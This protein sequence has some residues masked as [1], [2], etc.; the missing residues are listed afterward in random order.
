LKDGPAPVQTTNTEHLKCKHI[1]AVEFWL[2][3][4]GQ[5]DCEIIKTVIPKH[6]ENKTICPFCKSDQVTKKGIRRCKTQEKQ[7][8]LCKDCKKKFIGDKEFEK[9]K[10]SPEMITLVLD[11][12]FKGISLRKISDHIKQ[13]YGFDLGNHHTQVDTR[14]HADNKPIC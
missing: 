14:I 3:L 2:Q 7:R 8:Y 11:L 10:A 6:E 4:K 1:C 12:Y 5:T 9:I 13:I